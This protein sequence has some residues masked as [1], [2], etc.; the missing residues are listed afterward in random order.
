MIGL[1][2]GHVPG[3]KDRKIKS[4]ISED[5]PLVFNGVGEKTNEIKAI[6]HAFGE[7]FI[8]RFIHRILIDQ[9]GHIDDRASLAKVF[10]ASNALF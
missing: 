1:F 2:M 5:N 4:Y 6:F 8:D 3:Q 10:N 7:L 9:I